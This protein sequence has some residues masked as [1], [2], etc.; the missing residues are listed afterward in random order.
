MD[1]TDFLGMTYPTLPLLLLVRLV[2]LR[3]EERDWLGLG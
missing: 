2:W 1:P 3:H